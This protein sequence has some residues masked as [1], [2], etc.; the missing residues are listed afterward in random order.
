MTEELDYQVLDKEMDRVKTKVFLGS[1]AAFLGPLMCSVN[2]LWTE[3]IKT[4][5]TNGISLYWN[6]HWFLKLP[7]DTRITVLLHELWHIALLH[8]IRRGSRDLEIWNYACDINI[9]NML[10]AQG[11]SFAGTSPWIDASY[12]EQPTEEIYDSLYSMPDLSVLGDY[13]WGSEGWDEEGDKGDIVEP[14]EGEGDVAEHTIINKVVQASTA[15]KMSGAGDDGL[16]SEIDTMLKRFLQPKLPWELLLRQFFQALTGQ[17]YSWS[18][19]N[20]RYRDMYL[21]SLMEDESGLEHL[22]YYLDVSGSVSDGEVVRFNSEVKF[23][24]ETFNPHRLTLVLF[25]HQIQR[26]YDFYE[27]DPFEEIVI[28]GRGGT[29]LGPV[30]EH[31]LEHRPTAAVVFSDMC[32]APMQPLPPGIDI[33]TIW[34]GVNAG[35][36]TQ[37]HFGKLVHIKE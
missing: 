19:P 3:D 15:A 25:D 29:D 24:K 36:E 20:R 28:V 33:P 32:C 1:N 21:P 23:I 30:R 6:P 35:N 7:F 4:A 14:E 9:N 11:Y 13:V 18:R 8:M 34:V 27:D 10:K 17:D 2:F 16:P 26:E 22:I 37:V 12:G 5:Q 31:M